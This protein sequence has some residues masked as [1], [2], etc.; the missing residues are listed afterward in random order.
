MGFSIT[1]LNGQHGILAHIDIR[2]R[3]RVGQKLK[4]PVR[5]GAAAVARATPKARPTAAVP[6]D[7]LYKVRRGD[8]LDKIARR[9][10]V[11]EGDLVEVNNIRN[12]HRIRVGQVLQ[13]PGG[14]TTARPANG[15][16]AVPGVYTVRRGDTLEA[17]ARRFGV[18][19][20]AIVSLNGLKSR[21]RIAAG[22]KLY[23]PAAN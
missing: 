10:G 19:Q 21:H 2:N 5:G 18:S 13:I 17:I 22:Q 16:S 20:A 1:T 8:N 9:F 12:R 7:G 15:S 11:S 4:L 14:S 6:A 3:I 23:V